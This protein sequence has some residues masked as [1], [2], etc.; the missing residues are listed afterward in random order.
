MIFQ[1]HAAM[2]NRDKHVSRLRCLASCATALVLLSAEGAGAQERGEAI[3]WRNIL[4]QPPTWYGAA[5]AARI[6]DNVLLYQHDNGG[7]PKNVE[8]ARV[9]S[10]ADKD[11][12]RTTRNNAETTIDNGATHTQIRFL[13]LMHQTTGDERF[14]DGARR[15]IEYLLKAQYENGGWPQYYPLRE[16]YYTHIT[17]N[18]GAMIGAM[19]VLR[20]AAK[21]QPPYEFVDADLRQRSGQA[22]DRGVD[23]ILKCQIVVNGRLT[24]WCAQHDEIDFSPRGA[25]AYELPSLSGLESVG[26]VEFL[27]GIDHPSEEVKRAIRSA[28]EWLDQVKIEGM[29]VRW[30]RDAS[31]PRGGDRVIVPDPSAKPLWAR[32]YEIGTNQP[33]YVGRDGVAREKLADVEYERRV[34]YNWIGPF[35]AALLD[36]EYPMWRTKCS[37]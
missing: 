10:D 6:A 7:W 4:D 32:F 24:A 31:L 12:L 20:D 29:D 18:D 2:K 22:I 36:K 1:R 35:A 21:G 19:R 33:M 34:G 14:A 9:L 17:F 16:G 15:G 30:Q 13:A 11:H 27:M 23:V 3:R 28:V 37:E 25:R 8:M 5:E 26:I